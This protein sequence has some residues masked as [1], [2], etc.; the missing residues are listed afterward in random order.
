MLLNPRD[1]IEQGVLIVP[2]HLKDD[3]EKYIQ[4]NAI[5][6]TID[7]AFEHNPFSAFVIS[8]SARQHVEMVEQYPMRQLVK[9]HD[10]SEWFILK[11]SGQL[12]FVSDFAVKLPK[13]ISAM[14]IVRSSLNRNGIGL[15]AGLYDSE[16]SGNI[17][18]MLFNRR[19]VAAMIAPGTRIGQ[20]MFFESGTAKGYEG[21]YNNKSGHWT[22]AEP[23]A[24]EEKAVE[25]K[26]ESKGEAKVETVADKPTTSTKAKPAAKTTRKRTTKAT[27]TAT[28][29]AADAV[30]ADKSAD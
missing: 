23:V 8:E 9:G 29:K 5:D 28:T 13:G 24:V 1:M 16:F 11:R 15:T 19:D 18:G 3:I 30:E 12:D 27:A 10:A 26:T 2:E 7:R 17:G 21:V 4:P 25:N 22:D 6:F 20:I 14:L